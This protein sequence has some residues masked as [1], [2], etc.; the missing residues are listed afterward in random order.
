MTGTVPRENTPDARSAIISAAETLFADQSIE[1]VSLREIMRLAGQRNTT[2]LQYHFGSRDGLLRA[3]VEKHTAVVAVRRDALLD[4]LEAASNI[5]LRDVSSAFVAPL[6]AKLSDP[7]GGREFLRVAAQLVNRADRRIDPE[8][9]LGVLVFDHGGTIERWTTLA[10]PLMPAGTTGSPVHR[11]YA[12]IRFTH[13][14]LGRRAQL[15]ATETQALF[16]SQLTDL[17]TAILGTEVSAET[18]RLMRSRR[19]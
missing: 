16:A 7:D 4:Q 14:E 18:K 8:D 2:A 19:R 10:K 11:R 17:V 15:P 6:V 13:I 5:T 9:P 1:G 3:L 12:A